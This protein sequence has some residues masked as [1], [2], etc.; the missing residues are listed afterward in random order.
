MKSLEDIVKKETQLHV[1]FLLFMSGLR[2]WETISNAQ[3]MQDWLYSSSVKLWFLICQIRCI[4][5]LYFIVIDVVRS[6][7]AFYTENLSYEISNRNLSW[8]LRMKNHDLDI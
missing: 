2:K 6:S 8:W 7:E 4:S 3:T 1:V 5:V